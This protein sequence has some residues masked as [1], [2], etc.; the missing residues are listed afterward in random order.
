V[1]YASGFAW[2]VS[3]LA[4]WDVRARITSKILT[5]V[6]NPEKL[7]FRARE[8]SHFRFLMIL[9]PVT[10]FSCNVFK[11]VFNH[12]GGFLDDLGQ[13]AV[14]IVIFALEQRFFQVYLHHRD[15][16]VPAT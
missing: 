9:P 7:G 5:L 4:A 8:F 13:P 15:P 14:K 11:A 12:L 1:P 16:N 10:V 2:F 3:D 6:F